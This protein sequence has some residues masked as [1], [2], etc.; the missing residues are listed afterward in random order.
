MRVRPGQGPGFNSAMGTFYDDLAAWWPVISPV[1]EYAEEAAF[2]ASLLRRASIPVREVLE[3]GS[4][5]GHNA[6]HLKASFLMTLSDLSPGML[7]VSQALNPECR[8]VEADMRTLR[9]GESFDAV[10]IHDAIDYMLTEADLAAAI[11][12]AF[13]HCEPGGIAVFVPDSTTETFEPGADVG[14][15]DDPGGRAARIMDWTYDPDPAD[16]WV[17]TE[18]AFLLRDLDGMVRVEHES[19]RT[20][21]FS[22][23]VWLR[24]LRENGFEPEPVT[25]ETTEDRT[26]R[27]FFL[28]HRPV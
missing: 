20:G 18:Y 7:A 24:L 15:S 22:R 19:H 4:G 26:P 5:G 28:G 21:L 14:G 27:E 1:E 25:E 10:F 17:V 13:I 3:L 8:H 23:E 9:L 16:T 12:T 11:Q 6:A 2:A